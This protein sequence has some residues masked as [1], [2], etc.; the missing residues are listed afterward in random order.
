MR[1]RVD[2]IALAAL[3]RIFFFSPL[4]S[5]LPPARSYR[6]FARAGRERKLI[7]GERAAIKLPRGNYVEARIM[8]LC[9]DAARARSL[10]AS[11]F[12]NKGGRRTMTTLGTRF[13]SLLPRVSYR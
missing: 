4:P 7:L 11:A 10:R 5:F 1:R 12:N 8:R 9:P 2:K 13:D 3:A 6:F